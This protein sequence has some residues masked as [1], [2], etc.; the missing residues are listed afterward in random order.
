MYE[1]FESMSLE[2]LI[3]VQEELEIQLSERESEFERAEAREEEAMFDISISD[4]D[5]LGYSYVKSNVSANLGGCYE[6]LQVVKQQ[7]N[8]LKNQI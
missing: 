5:F 8:K 2:K 1:E 4:D 3:Q 7:I 6:I